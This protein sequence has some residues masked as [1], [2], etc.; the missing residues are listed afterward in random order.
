MPQ[1]YERRKQLY[2]SQAIRVAVLIII[3]T[4]TLVNRA[5][6]NHDLLSRSG[7]INLSRRV[8]LRVNFIPLSSIV[9]IRKVIPMRTYPIW[10]A[11][12]LMATVCSAQ[13]QEITDLFSNI[14][15]SDVT[16]N[17]DVI[18]SQLHLELLSGGQVIQTRTLD[19][20]RPGT[21]VAAW[22]L[23]GAEKGSYDVCASLLSGGKVQSKRCYNFFYAGQTPVRFDV[24]DFNADS[25]GIHLSILSADPTIVDIYYM[26]IVGNKALYISKDESVPISSGYPLEIDRPWHQILKDGQKYYGRVKIVEINGNLTRAF[27]MPFVAKDDAMITDT[28]ED[29]TGASATVLGNSRVPFEGRLRFVLSQNGTVLQTIE[30]KTPVLLSGKDETVEVSWNNTLDPGIYQL[31]VVLLGNMGDTL[32][33]DESII[34]AKPIANPVNATQPQKKSPMPEGAALAALVATAA[35]IRRQR[36]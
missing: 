9:Q 20:D 31:Q 26:L 30:K 29:E 16:V 22:N 27:M 4:A 2:S 3:L 15:S 36:A 21:W 28:Y 6:I 7:L 25:K 32:D 19:M 35:I 23:S 5:G 10:L 12:A 17:G 34:E 24:R 13:S 11:I 14:E 1:G 18:G 33:M 8:I